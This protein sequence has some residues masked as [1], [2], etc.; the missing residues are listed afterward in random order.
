MCETLI[1]FC[2]SRQKDTNL[3]KSPTLNRQ[4]V[5]TAIESRKAF[6]EKLRS[7]KKSQFLEVETP[8]EVLESS[9]KPTVLRSKRKI[10]EDIVS[11][12]QQDMEPI[13]R[14]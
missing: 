14:L 7:Q 3:T 11:V 8:R 9:R 12:D 5:R 13:R 10:K 2:S 6:L 1:I 4:S